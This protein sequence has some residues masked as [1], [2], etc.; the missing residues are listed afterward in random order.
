M[1][2]PRRRRLP[3]CRSPHPL[4][5][6]RTRRRSTSLRTTTAS[7][8]TPPPLTAPTRRPLCGLP[9]PETATMTTTT[10]AHRPVGRVRCRPLSPAA[11]RQ[12]SLCGHRPRSRPARSWCGR[13]SSWMMSRSRRATAARS[14]TCCAGLTSG[15]SSRSFRA[16]RGSRRLRSSTARLR[17][18]ARSSQSWRR[19]LR[20]IGG[21]RRCC[22]PSVAR[23]RRWSTSTSPSARAPACPPTGLPTRRHTRRRRPPRRAASSLPTRWASAR[24]TRPSAR[25]SCESTSRRGAAS[26]WPSCRPSSSRPTTT[27]SA[28]GATR[29]TARFKVL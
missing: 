10:T 12:R 19:S 23:G 25:W 13:R 3:R 22:S 11:S 26:R 9:S 20:Q 21:C 6:S 2:Q 16:R 4:R 14:P 7:S 24:P 29:N 15:R 28:S 8:S 17:C 1:W 27:C 5:Q 18:Q